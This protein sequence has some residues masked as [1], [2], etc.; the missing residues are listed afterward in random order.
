MVCLS[1]VPAPRRDAA[2]ARLAHGRPP[3]HRLVR[4]LRRDAGGGAR[5]HR[6]RGAAA[7]ARQHREGARAGRRGGAAAGQESRRRRCS[8]SPARTAWRTSSSAAR[9]PA[10]GASWL[11]P[12]RSMLRLVRRGRRTSTCTV[13]VAFPRGGASMTLRTKL[14]LAQAPLALALVLVGVACGRSPWPTS[15]RARERI[16]AGQLPQRARRAADEGV[17]RAHRQ[18]GPLLLAGGRTTRGLRR[19]PRTVRASSRS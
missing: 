9:R 14:L 16:L 13:V 6:R 8:T 10:A 1:S 5:P 17:H 7:P 15:A 3:Q 11:R 18:R 2:A 12:D 4:G 19:P